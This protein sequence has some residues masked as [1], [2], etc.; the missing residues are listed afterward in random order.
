[1]WSLRRL[2]WS[3]FLRSLDGFK[4]QTATK[5]KI[6]W[7]KEDL[8]LTSSNYDGHQLFRVWVNLR[9]HFILY[10]VP[11]WVNLEKKHFISNFV[12]LAIYETLFYYRFLPNGQLTNHSAFWRGSSWN[13]QILFVIINIHHHS[14]QPFKTIIFTQKYFVTFN[15]EESLITG[16]HLK[17]KGTPSPSSAAPLIARPKLLSFEVSSSFYNSNCLKVI[18]MNSWGL[19]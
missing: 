19:M 2:L 13:S 1:M 17:D 7:R 12:Q 14:F 9:K 18:I 4:I 11:L 16:A 15:K 8:K 6:F 10:F 5:K 3:C